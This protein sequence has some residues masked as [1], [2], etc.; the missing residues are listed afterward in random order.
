MGMSPRLMRPRATVHPEAAAWAA[1]VV[2]NGGTV[3]ASLAA[4]SNFCKAIDAAGIRDRFFRLNLLCGGTSGTAVG[5]NSCLVPLYRS[6]SFGGTT[7]GFNADDNAG[8][9]FVGGD[10]NATGSSGGLAGGGTRY[11]N[12]GLASNVLSAGDR[13]LSAY[14]TVRSGGVFQTFVGTDE[15]GSERF[16]LEYGGSGSV[17]NFGYGAYSANISS[18]SVS[19]GAHW[20]GVNSPATAGQLYRNGTPETSTT[21]AAQTLSSRNLFV[22][23]LNRTGSPTSYYAGRLGSYSIGA[24]MT[25]TQAAAYYAALQAFQTALG[26]NV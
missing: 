10:Y 23:A 2:A 20:I 14:E 15:A 5:L 16:T 18:S 4:V 9:V 13:H 1:R 12:T 8:G 19:T 24:A 21:Q 26:R 3:G 22:Y 25:A 17:I 6:R 7:Y 11:L